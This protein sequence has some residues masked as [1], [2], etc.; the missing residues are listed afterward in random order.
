MK[1]IISLYILF[2]IFFNVGLFAQDSTS[3]VKLSQISIDE[4]K[5]NSILTTLLNQANAKESF[6][7][8]NKI[9]A[10]II[11]I[12]SPNNFLFYFSKDKMN[13]FSNID[14]KKLE[15]IAISEKKLKYLLS[16]NSN[17]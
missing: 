16:I 10:T 3:R 11:E 17:Q 5:N 15:N 2:N 4:L 6:S 14:R 1:K 7:N 12:K 8:I 9:P 13:N